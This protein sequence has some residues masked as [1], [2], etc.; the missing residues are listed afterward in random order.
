MAVLLGIGYP[1]S[2]S[3]RVAIL[4][5]ASA[6]DG[7]G[8][9]ANFGYVQV[10]AFGDAVA[11]RQVGVPARQI[12]GFPRFDEF[13]REGRWQPGF[14]RLAEMSSQEAAAPFADGNTDGAAERRRG[15]R[16]PPL[17]PQ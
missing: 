6:V 1:T 13:E 16:A 9:H 11:Q 10:P 14:A 15:C 2:A 3:E 17:E 8:D 12:S 5:V 7:A 4:A